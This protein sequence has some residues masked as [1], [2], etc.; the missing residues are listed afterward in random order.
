MKYENVKV[1]EINPVVY[2]GEE[3]I[4]N[5][6]KINQNIFKGKIE[7]LHFKCFFNYECPIKDMISISVDYS[8]D[9]EPL[10]KTSTIDNILGVINELLKVF[11]DVKVNLHLDNFIE[12]KGNSID[13][14][15][16]EFINYLMEETEK[17]ESENK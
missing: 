17:F 15:I 11:S 16:K 10:A 6:W 5:D 3:F 12:E 1:L 9:F 8:D 4:K 14:D 7:G 13:L 2:L